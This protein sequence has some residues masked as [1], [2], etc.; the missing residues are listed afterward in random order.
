[1]TWLSAAVLWMSFR[2]H[3]RWKAGVVKHARLHVKKTGLSRIL[4]IVQVCVVQKPELLLFQL[5]I[6]IFTC[7][8][9][10]RT[11]LCMCAQLLI[12][13]HEWAMWVCCLPEYLCIYRE[14]AVYHSVTSPAQYLTNPNRQSW[15]LLHTYFNNKPWLYI[16]PLSPYS[17]EKTWCAERA[18]SRQPKCYWRNSC[19]L[20]IGHFVSVWKLIS[21]SC[22]VC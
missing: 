17:K 6:D 5:A 21:H 14:K 15:L 18:K 22:C 16:H 4:Y 11:S 3:W 8:A 13:I 1:M 12:D 7:L 20:I 2:W 19:Q 10:C 9:L